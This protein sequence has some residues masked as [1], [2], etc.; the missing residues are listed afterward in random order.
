MEELNELLA[1]IRQEVLVKSGEDAPQEYLESSFTEWVLEL[2][3]EC[4]EA[5]GWDLFYYKA[6][7]KKG[8]PAAK[9]NAWAL[10]GDGAT[11]DLFVTFYDG[12]KKIA[13][14]GQ[15][16]IRKLY[17]QLLG[18]L[19]R[20][21]EG[22][23]A[24]SDATNAVF[25]VAKRINDAADSL[26]TVR[27]FLLT[28]CLV[29]NT[30]AIEEESISGLDVRYVLWD[31]RKLSQL[32]VDER[33]EIELDFK[34]E[35][36]DSIPCLI[37]GTSKHY[38]TYLAFMSGQVLARIYGKY[39]QRLLERNV[40][41]FL[42]PT[43]KINKGLQSTI[44]EEP[45]RFLAYNNGLCCTAASVEFEQRPDG[46]LGL[47]AASDLQIV[48]G[49]QTTAS[50]YHAHKGAGGKNRVDVTKVMV[51][52]KL[53]V[54]NRQDD[55][56]EMVPLIAKYANSQNK[57]NAADLAANGTFH[58]DIEQLS[59]KIPAPPAAGLQGLSHWFYERARGSYKYER[60]DKGSARD[61]A[62]KEW[63]KLYPIERKFTK[64]DLAKYENAWAGL[65]HLVCLGAEKNFT[66]FAERMEAE[67]E[68]Q[69]SVDTFKHLIAKAILWRATEKI[70]DTLELDGFRSNSVAYSI[71]W[72][73][74][75][76]ERRIDLDQIWKDQR[77][78]ALMCE[79][80]KVVCNLAW[81]HISRQGGNQN[82]ASKKLAC[83]ESFRDK[84]IALPR[85]WNQDLA[86]TS[87]VTANNEEEVL[88]A[89]WN[90]VRG[91]FLD[92][93]RTIEGLEANTSMQWEKKQR[94]KSVPSFATKSWPELRKYCRAEGVAFKKIRTLIEM[95]E[96]AAQD[97]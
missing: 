87:F 59:R 32:S 13:N 60:A 94:R 75:K 24:Q 80:I 85:N 42:S 62:R 55:L 12:G 15:T 76:S 61:K 65:P 86:K 54:L 51:Q 19:Q 43:G 27:V 66:K 30:G 28:D 50:I 29:P 16:E 41:A 39:G 71:A 23:Y 84:D 64:T 48:N 63:E 20:V 35:S 1:D 17:K 45:E 72:L 36:G 47:V 95:L 34:E 49:G 6:E 74:E 58:R 67:G 57:V 8:A 97:R 56:N 73:A 37:G 70:F 26:S 46:Q 31:L 25:G 11:L 69:V 78:T 96:I 5:N 89:A 21:R 4:N 79:T 82:E 90:R 52:V 10:S 53:T 40:R 14:L 88:E 2:L 81:E 22:F 33:G 38:K 93:P 44:K 3:A 91:D 68:P 7:G 9:I 92:D 77:L 18:F 83:W